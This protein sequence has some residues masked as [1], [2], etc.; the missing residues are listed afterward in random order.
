MPVLFVLADCPEQTVMSRLRRR[1]TAASFS[2]ADLAVYRQMKSRFKPPR[3]GRD[4]VRINTIQPVRAS[5]AR[6]ERALLRI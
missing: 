1:K 4:L 3:P 6:I 2:D 5:L